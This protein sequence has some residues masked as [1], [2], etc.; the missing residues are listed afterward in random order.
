[1]LMSAF[2]VPLPRLR[3]KQGMQELLISLSLSHSPTRDRQTKLSITTASRN[4]NFRLVEYVLNGG[5]SSE[6]TA[7]FLD[8]IPYR[9]AEREFTAF[10]GPPG[11]ILHRVSTTGLGSKKISA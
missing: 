6:V 8:K 3:T 4:S 5:R 11:K 2:P 9:L 7:R 1:M 10:L